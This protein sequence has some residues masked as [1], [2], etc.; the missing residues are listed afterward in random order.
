M[1]DDVKD[2]IDIQIVGEFDAKST[3]TKVY[4]N[5]QI[6]YILTENLQP[7]GLTPNQI[8]AITITSVAIV[9]FAIIA[10]L[11]VHK[12][13]NSKKKIEDIEPDILG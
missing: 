13:K 7:N 10:L 2:G 12:N 11:F 9:A 1:F 4:Y 6:G 3:F 8:I 5:E